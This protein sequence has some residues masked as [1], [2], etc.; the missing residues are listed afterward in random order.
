MA[1]VIANYFDQITPAVNGQ[2]HNSL[3]LSALDAN[4]VVFNNMTYSCVW[5]YSIDEVPVHLM[6]PSF[7]RWYVLRC[8]I[9]DLACTF[10]FEI[11]IFS[12]YPA[13]ISKLFASWA[14]RNLH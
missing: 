11:P 14:W 9:E 5:S 13:R 10:V 8:P 2:Y 3:L 4:S 7:R 6:R 12:A 1:P